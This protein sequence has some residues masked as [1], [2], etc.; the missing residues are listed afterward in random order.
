MDWLRRKLGRATPEESSA[1]PLFVFGP[2]RSGTTLAAKLLNAHPEVVVTNETRVL[3]FFEQAL[4]QIPT[5]DKGGLHCARVHGDLIAA[6]L[7]LAGRGVVERAYRAIA[8]AEG[9]RRIRYWGDKNPHV[10]AA[11]DLLEDWF[12]KAAL[13]AVRRDPRDTVCSILELWS[14]MDLVPVRGE[15]DEGWDIPD[16]KLVQ[17]CATVLRALRAEDAYLASRDPADVFILDYERLLRDGSAVLQ[18]LFV[19]F[20][21][22]AD[23]KAPTQAMA[24]MRER[25]VHGAI[26]GRVDFLT[27][28]LGRWQRDLSPA[29]QAIVAEQCGGYSL[30]SNS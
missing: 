1:R 11:L 15:G 6:E 5:G 25:D 28:S 9:K 12:P 23:A 20:L 22:L 26:Q 27:R 8:E 18:A 14:R 30:P 10:S 4:K 3:T 24:A 7:R 17:C 21:G 19:D 2:P 13:V 16:E 29:Q